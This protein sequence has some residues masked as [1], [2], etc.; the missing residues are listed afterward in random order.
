MA[1]VARTGGAPK[2]KASGGSGGGGNGG[3]RASSNN[4]H[5][6]YHCG[7]RGH[8]VANCPPPLPIP[9]AT[10]TR[11]ESAHMAMGNGF[12]EVQAGVIYNL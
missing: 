5:T 7:Q 4:Y 2:G 8:I 6:C 10:P 9:V 11:V 3:G 12:P 1:I